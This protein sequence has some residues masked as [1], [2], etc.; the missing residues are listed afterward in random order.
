VH[1]EPNLDLSHLLPSVQA[2]A[3]L[4][5]DERI[6]HVRA[7]R[8]IGYPRALAALDRLET[9]FAW[10]S[11]QRMPNL[12]LIRPTNNGKS[13]LIQ[14]FRR[15]HPSRVLPDREDLPVLCAQMPP[16]PSVSRFYM[17]LLA[18]LGA[19]SDLLISPHGVT[20]TPERRNPR[21]RRALC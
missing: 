20:P 12:L 19:P 13:M 14:K 2:K 1:D 21:Q 4:P 5:A 11:R 10:P 7:D 8:W 17:A 15:S 6:R 9:L 16:E 3:R 18:A